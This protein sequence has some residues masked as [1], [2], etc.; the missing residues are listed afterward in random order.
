MFSYFWPSMEFQFVA[1]KSDIGAGKRGASLGFD[2]VKIAAI[3]QQFAHLNLFDAPIVKSPPE[4]QLAQRD[5]GSARYIQDVGQI[6][7]AISLA[8][9]AQ[10][11]VRKFP[12]VFSGDH[13]NAA[14]TICGIKTAFPNSRL[15]VIWIDAHA[16]LHSPF[17]SPSGNIHGMPLALCAA[18][19]NR[20]NQVKPPGKD[21][22]DA[23]NKLK[24]I[25]PT[26]KKINLE[27][28]VFIGL[29]SFESPEFQLI[30]KHHVHT[31]TVEDVQQ[32]GAKAIRQQSL[33]HLHHCDLIYVSF[34]VD[35][36]DPS[37]SRG[38]GTPVPKGLSVELAKELISG[39]VKNEKVCCLE[40][41]ELNP[42]L[43]TENKMAKV[44]LEIVGE[45]VGLGVGV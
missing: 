44:V 17:T 28:V 10:V 32:Q 22:I 20:Q 18:E 24:K 7:E 13:G 12:I 40:I 19:D 14:G 35:S 11:S 29:R 23:W 25:G 26:E 39:F 16:D 34:D 36:L 45:V 2:A 8:V 9:A 42:L 21:V 38:T 5:V 41:T 1:V 30:E 3:Q 33:D 37:V 31:I 4:V 6:Y 15:G 43:D 27:D